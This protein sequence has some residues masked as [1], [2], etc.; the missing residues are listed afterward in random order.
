LVRLVAG[1]PK[2]RLL[3][4]VLSGTFLARQHGEL[5]ASADDLPWPGFA[6]LQGEYRRARSVPEQRAVA[7]NFERL[8][9]GVLAQADELGIAPLARSLDEML[10]ELGPADSVKQVVAFF[11]RFLRHYQANASAGKPFTLAPFQRKFIAEFWRR[12]RYGRRVYQVGL[13]GV[14]KGNGKTPLAAGLGLHALVTGKNS[15][16]V[17]GIAGSKQQAAL[18]LAFAQRWA[19]EGELAHWLTPGKTINCVER[20]G[21]Y[22]ILSS[23]GRLAQGVNPSAAIV[24]EW[25]L[26]DHA[27]ER[28][29]YTALSQALHK[30]L[31]ESWLLAITT[32]GW[33]KH[34]QLGETYP[35]ALNHPKL[36]TDRDGHLLVLR[37]DQARWRSSTLCGCQATSHRCTSSSRRSERSL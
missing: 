1:R 29:S 4:H 25:W 15:P 3:D 28:E 2:K 30:R 6:A 32:A 37:D 35:A 14:P 9:R 33:N 36:E 18:A 13:L 26:F 31:G 8:V 17:Y 19:D 12:D 22:R 20:H 7:L 21:T 23:D 16:D 5:L 11:P 10:A 27:R 24:D 34:S